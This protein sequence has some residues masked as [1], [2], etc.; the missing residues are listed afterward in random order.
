VAY[1]LRSRQVDAL[2]RKRGVS[3]DH[4]TIN[5]WALKDAPPREEALHRRKHPS[6]DPLTD[7]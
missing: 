3:V 1:P 2:M 6:L 4:A 5:H 7:G